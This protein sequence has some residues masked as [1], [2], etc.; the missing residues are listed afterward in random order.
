MPRETCPGVVTFYQG[1]RSSGTRE[2]LTSASARE[3]FGL[4]A[5]SLTQG[6]NAC[7]RASVAKIYF[8]DC[9]GMAKPIMPSRNRSNSRE[10]GFS[11]VF[12]GDA[13]RPGELLTKTSRFSRIIG[14][15]DWD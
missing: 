5:Q 8:D 4:T 12:K 1:T 9:S 10:G 13:L 14:L 15:V 11:D 3:I 2:N 6:R 7:E